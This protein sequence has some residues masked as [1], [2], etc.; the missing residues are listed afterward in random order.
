[1][2]NN[3]DHEKMILETKDRKL[4]IGFFKSSV[5]LEK[6][7]YKRSIPHQELNER[8]PHLVF[9]HDFCDY[10]NR[11]LDIANK[12]MSQMG[13]NLIVS[14]IDMKGHGLSSG[15]RAHIDSFDEYVCDM[16]FFLDLSLPGLKLDN[17]I[18]G[19]GLGALIGI[20]LF[21]ED[22]YN[23]GTLSGMIFSNL[24]THIN[25]N[26]PEWSMKI[27][28]RFKSSLG[29]IR[30]PLPLLGAEFGH[31][32]GLDSD[33]LINKNL[34]IST[35]KEILKASL[36]IRSACYF[37]NLPTLF[38]IGEQGKLVNVESLKL[39]C[40]GA[41][42]ALCESQ[43]YQNSGHDL[44]NDLDRDIVQIDIYNWIKTNFLK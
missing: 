34:P 7:Y 22:C 10:H 5:G 2:S 38:L 28:K 32:R 42:K 14:W 40:K 6:I 37:I 21:Q 23:K 11:Y 12:L 8:I 4:I 24:P 30:M 25:L 13:N 9:V 20:K 44:F 43:V 18:V 35:I 29:K 19:Q 41:P 31:E 15:R 17:I 1:M 36:S 26:F 33:P 39:L 16:K 27:L 3:E